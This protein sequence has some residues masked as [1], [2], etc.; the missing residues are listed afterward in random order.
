[1]RRME[2]AYFVLLATFGCAGILGPMTKNNGVAGG[3]PM[4]IPI[5]FLASRLN[6]PANG[7]T[8]LVVSPF[9]L[10]SAVVCGAVS[11]AGVKAGRKI[12]SMLALWRQASR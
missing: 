12:F 7:L 1:M 10:A 8:L 2:P 6:G 11:Y 3:L 9:L 5:I 4:L